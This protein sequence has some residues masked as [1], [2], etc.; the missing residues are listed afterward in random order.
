MPYQVSGEPGQGSTTDFSKNSYAY[1]YPNNL[2]LKPGS[3]FHNELKGKILTRARES[4]NEMTKRFPSWNEVDR[5]LTTYIPLKDKEEMLKSKDSSKP[6]SIVFPYTYAM[7][8]ALLTYLSMAFFQDPIFQY[9][10]VGPEDVQGTMLLERVIRLHCIKTKVPLAIHTVLRNALAYGIGPGAPGWKKSYGFK[11]VQ[12]EII[13]LDNAGGESTSRNVTYVESLIFEGNKLDAIDPYMYLPDPS[14]SAHEI[15]SGEFVGWVVRDNLM[16][17]LS[18]EVSSDGEIF[19][20]KYLKALKNRKSSFS[21]DQSDR[22]IKYGGQD[23][24]NTTATSTNHVDTIYMYI[25]LIPKEWKLGSSE[26][27]EKWLF[28]LSSDEVITSASKVNHAHGMFPVAVAAPE[29]DGFSPTPIGRLE[30]LY[31]LQ[32]TLDFLFN[33]YDDKTEVLT[34]IGWVKF[35]NAKKANLDVATVDPDNGSMWFEKPKE[36]FEYDYDGNLKLFE[37]KRYSL[38]VT[39]NHQMFGKYRHSNVN[40]FKVANTV[41]DRSKWDEFKIPMAV[42]FCGL[43]PQSV[44]VKQAERKGNTG[45]FPRQGDI[46]VD[47]GT[48][49][50]FLGWFLSDGSITF[51]KLS[52]TYSVT[53]KQSKKKHFDSIDHY[54]SN[55]PFHS[56]KYYDK[57]KKSWQWTITDK[58]FYIWLKIN[59]YYGGT[60]G[61]YK[62][63]PDIIRNADRITLSRF[64]ECFVKGDGHVID[65]HTNLYQIGTESKQLANDLQ[66]IAIKLGYSCSVR[67]TLTQS[68]K[69]FYVLNVNKDAP[70]ATLTN[71]NTTNMRYKG[72]VYCFEN[73]THLTVVR[74]NGKVSICGQSHIANVRKSINDMFVVDPYLININDLKDPQPGKLIRLRRPAWGRGVDKVVQQLQVNDITRN[75]IADSSY[76]TQWMDKI[77]GADQSMMGSLRQGGPERLTKGE[78]QGT[79]GSAISRLQRIASIIGMQFMQDI[80]Y[81]FAVHTQQYMSQD[82]YVKSIGRDQEKMAEIFGKQE[83]IP[84]TPFDLSVEYDVI[85]KDGSIPGGNFSEIWVQLFQI[86]GNSEQLSQEFDVFRLFS[87]IATELG[88]KNIEDFK[89]NADRIQ[90]TMM[91]DEKAMREVDK[92][93]LVP[94]G[95]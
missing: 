54:F 59:C 56:N 87:Y 14:V 69:S 10:G 75:N 43:Q 26:Y 2:N 23:P 5:V 3:E 70:W 4:R 55:L 1:E 74:R 24:R 81:M 36:W 71:K 85:V 31:G 21:T 51:G 83:R 8:E 78:F 50:G 30:I 34:S 15:Q 6:I 68:G 12:S 80:G 11:P 60:T 72:K 40:E 92:G 61:E 42:H 32:H 47:P 63:V 13:T 67:N 49:S 7:L 45:R 93:N 64:F 28:S 48:L 58:A 79:R 16:N 19:N 62:E 89:R 44:I 52:G 20:V 91:D 82:T 41:F 88:A 18:E 94:T 84:V 86:I 65:G 77:S 57:D 53:V 25:N 95:A 38:A 66:E 39:P 29:F 27:P 9:E 73:S 22:N 17:M 46:E 33:C 76:I 37:S 35:S 90:P